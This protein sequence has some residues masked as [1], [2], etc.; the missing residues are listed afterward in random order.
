MK[1]IILAATVLFTSLSMM[2]QNNG[3]VVIHSNGPFA[4]AF[5]IIEGTSIDLSVSRGTG[6]SG[7]LN[8]F[9]FFDIVQPTADGFI[10]TFASGEIP[11][12]SLQGDDPA[13]M[14]LD[15]DTSQLTNFI[16][17]T[18][19]ISF[20]D[21]TPTCGPGTASGLIHLEWRK[22]NLFTTHTSTDMQ[23]TFFQTRINSHQVTDAAFTTLTGSFFGQDVTNGS[24]LAG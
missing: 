24:G 20:T 4:Q 1:S 15:V 5:A 3:P 19:T 13:H 17:S 18:C 12:S 8:T 14:V 9:L 16:S 10:D 2:A 11:N 22:A 7:Q 6:A 21:S 23:Q